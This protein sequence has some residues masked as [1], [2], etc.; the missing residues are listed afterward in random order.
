VRVAEA[1]KDG[2][3]RECGG[4]LGSAVDDSVCGW[5]GTQI[6]CMADPLW[7]QGAGLL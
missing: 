2:V 5:I 7:G 1:V 4:Q 6:W 3:A